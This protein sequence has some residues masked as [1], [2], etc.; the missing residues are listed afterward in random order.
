MDLKLHC[1]H[2]AALNGLDSSPQCSRRL[3]DLE[4]VNE[5]KYF[6]TNT[7]KL[8]ATLGALAVHTP[9]AVAQ[10]QVPQQR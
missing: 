2:L 6:S 10:Q 7:I 8:V 5:S 3:A 4:P 9:Q 1:T